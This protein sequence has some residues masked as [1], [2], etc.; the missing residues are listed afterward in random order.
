MPETSDIVTCMILAFW[1]DCQ[2]VIVIEAE[3]SFNCVVVF[4]RGSNYLCSLDRTCV[5]IQNIL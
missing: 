2:D 4:I 5:C 1:N 3:V